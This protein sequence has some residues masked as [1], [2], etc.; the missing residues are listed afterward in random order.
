M[1]PAEVRSKI[2]RAVPRK[3]TKPEIYVHSLLHELGF[4][5]RLH[6]KN[7]PGTPDIF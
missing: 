3:N 4:R 6:N 2:M 5:F 7:L 1:K